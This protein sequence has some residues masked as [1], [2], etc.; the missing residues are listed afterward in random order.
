MDEWTDGTE[1]YG[2]EMG[3]RV[4][5]TTNTLVSI[6]FYFSLSLSLSLSLI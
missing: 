1:R 6:F 2:P 4:P 3:H 5:M